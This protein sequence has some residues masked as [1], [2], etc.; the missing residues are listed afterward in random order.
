MCIGCH[1]TVTDDI[2]ITFD[3]YNINLNEY[4]NL[5]N[6]VFSDTSIYQPINNKDSDHS[7]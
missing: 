3:N 5:S 1:E 7:K 6:N 4:I 2:K